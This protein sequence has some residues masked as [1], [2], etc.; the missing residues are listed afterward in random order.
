MRLMAS[1]I[2]AGLLLFALVALWRYPLTRA[3]LAEI[4]T[5]LAARRAA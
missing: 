5:L 3:R 1:W 4:K 2:P